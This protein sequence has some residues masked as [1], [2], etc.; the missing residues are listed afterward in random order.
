MRALLSIRLFVVAALIGLLAAAAS[1]A[2]AAPQNQEPMLTIFAIGFV[3]VTGGDD[4]DCPG[5]NG[6]F[7]PE[8]ETFAQAN[9]LGTLT[10]EVEDDSGTVIA[11]AQTEALATLQRAM[12]DVPD[13]LDGESYLLKLTNV[14]APWVLCRNF[15]AERR[16]TIDDFQLGSTRQDFYF[17]QGCDSDPNPTAVPSAQPT[18]PGQTAVPTVPGQPNPTAGPKPTSVPGGGNSGGDDD[19]DDDKGSSGGSSGGSGASGGSAGG[20]TAGGGTAAGGTNVPGPREINGLVFIDNNKDGKLGGD[21]PGVAGVQVDLSGG[22]LQVS[23]YTNGLGQFNFAGLG[24]GEYDVKLIVGSEWTISTPA[25]Y[26]VKV[27]SKVVGVDFGIHKGMAKP[28]KTGGNMVVR[29]MPS[30]GIADLPTG[31]LLGALVL[32]LGLIAGLGFV[33]ERRTRL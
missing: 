10:F 14:P 22:G 24:A 31:G 21:E 15:S 12:I 29:M 7:D 11:T 18:V 30:T 5:C 6:S 20:S 13:L 23:T 16:L 1:P 3:D 9:P 32:A 4:P 19:D 28:A 8:D 27:T 33:M 17:D 26:T 2:S 25:I